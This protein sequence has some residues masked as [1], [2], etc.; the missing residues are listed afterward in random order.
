MSWGEICITIAAIAGATMLSRSLPFIV[1]SRIKTPRYV[2][3]LGKTLP[4]AAMGLLVVYC[5]KDVS[6]ASAP[7]GAPEMIAA[8]ATAIIHIALRKTL[9][10]IAAGTA[11]YI[12]LINFVFTS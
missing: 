1:F 9:L 2:E 5:F 6:F 7:Y 8:V 4:A 3:Y 11:T 12:C 10:S